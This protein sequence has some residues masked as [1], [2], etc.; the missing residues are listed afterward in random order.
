MQLERIHATQPAHPC[1]ERLLAVGN[2]FLAAVRRD[3]LAEQ[4]AAVRVLIEVT[5]M[6]QKAAMP[7]YASYLECLEGYPISKLMDAPDARIDPLLDDWLI[8][9]AH[10]EGMT[11]RYAERRIVTGKGK[12]AENAVLPIGVV[13]E[14]VHV[15]SVSIQ[16]FS[17]RG[18]FELAELLVVAHFMVVVQL[19]TNY[20]SGH[21]LY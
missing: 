4:R 7:L 2:H 6:E 1:F 13:S 17:H 11:E 8:G 20:Q 12:V 15:A 3:L 10:W 5:S 14:Q 19:C 18:A 16:P 9:S 21:A